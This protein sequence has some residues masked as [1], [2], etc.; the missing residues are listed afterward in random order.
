MKKIRKIL[1]WLISEDDKGRHKVNYDVGKTIN[2]AEK[3]ISNLKL[4][5]LK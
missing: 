5:D 4:K 1:E 2:K 3:K